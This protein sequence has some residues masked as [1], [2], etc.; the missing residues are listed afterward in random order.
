MALPITLWRNNYDDTVCGGTSGGSA[1]AVLNPA[2]AKNRGR[3][4]FNDLR[5]IN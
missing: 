3:R 2:S 1:S 4:S 5:Q